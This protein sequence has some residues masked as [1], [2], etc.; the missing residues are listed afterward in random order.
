MTLFD[1]EE[2]MRRKSRVVDVDEVQWITSY[3]RELD[4]YS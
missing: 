3:H 2:I 4:T 1:V